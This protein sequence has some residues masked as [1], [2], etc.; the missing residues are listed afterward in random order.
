[1]FDWDKERIRI[2]DTVQ[3]FFNE[4]ERI[5]CLKSQVSFAKDGHHRKEDECMETSRQQNYKLND[6]GS[7]DFYVKKNSMI[8]WKR[9]E[10]PGHYAYKGSGIPGTQSSTTYEFSS[11]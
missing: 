5:E 1:M 7:W 3:E 10:E 9:E 6:L 11:F 8:T 4:F 2:D